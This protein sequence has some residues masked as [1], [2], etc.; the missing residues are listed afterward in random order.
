ML[1]GFL[2]LAN[3][4]FGTC[5]IS[6]ARPGIEPPSAQWLHARGRPQSA[7]AFTVS[8][9]FPAIMFSGP[10]DPGSPTARREPAGQ[11]S[12]FQDRMD[13]LVMMPPSD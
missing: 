2:R 7:A 4:F 3:V 10:C 12:D 13:R 9:S 6:S 1:A 5:A 11:A 8:S